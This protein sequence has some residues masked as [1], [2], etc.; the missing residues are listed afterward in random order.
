MIIRLQKINSDMGKGNVYFLNLKPIAHKQNKCT[1]LAKIQQQ[2]LF[3][4][5]V[6]FP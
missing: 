4:H 1:G 5:P 3:T 6:Y 2:D